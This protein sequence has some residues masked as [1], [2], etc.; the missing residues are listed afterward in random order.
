[1]TM[2]IIGSLF[3]TEEKQKLVVNYKII[4]QGGL[5]S[6]EKGSCNGCPLWL[7][8]GWTSTWVDIWFHLGNPFCWTLGSNSTLFFSF[9]LTTSLVIPSL[10]LQIWK[11]IFKFGDFQERKKHPSLKTRSTSTPHCTWSQMWIIWYWARETLYYYY[12][13]S[14]NTN[15]IIFKNVENFKNWFLS[16]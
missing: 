13:G 7:G 11:K 3:T 6:L 16:Q 12:L 4:S 5:Q 8:C 10:I 15:Y 2:F 9:C 1:M 14:F